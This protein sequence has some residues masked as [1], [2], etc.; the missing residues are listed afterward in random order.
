MPQQD[1]ETPRP[2][3]LCRAEQVSTGH[4]QT[5]GMIRQSAIVDKSPSICGTLMRA[6]PH[7]SSAVHHHGTQDTIVYAVSGIGAIASLD[8][9]GNEQKQI[10]SPG[11]WALI[12]ANREHKEVNDGDEEVVW[13]IHTVN[14][15]GSSPSPEDTI[16]SQV[17]WT[18]TQGDEPCSGLKSYVRDDGNGHIGFYFCEH[19]G[20]MT[21]WALTE[22]GLAFIRERAAKQGLEAPAPSV[23][24]NCRMLSPRLIEGVERRAGKDGDF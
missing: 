20:C 4:G 23:G 5:E 17:S 13:V 12:P 16:K 7:S 21:H 18:P 9:E 19:C 1:R 15:P 22:K 2:V 10:L 24:I 11:D 3:H 14:I 6:Q 8:D